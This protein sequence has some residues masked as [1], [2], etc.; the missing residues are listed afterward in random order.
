MVKV[1]V[2]SVSTKELLLM[3]TVCFKSLSY[4]VIELMYL[5]QLYNFAGK[6]MLV[7]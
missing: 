6:P 2:K 1:G 5:S 7:G 3:I 4:L